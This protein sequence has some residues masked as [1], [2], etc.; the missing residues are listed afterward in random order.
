MQ[1]IGTLNSII[2]FL[3]KYELKL[4]Y[5]HIKFGAYKWKWCIETFSNI[6][7]ECENIFI[8]VTYGKS[9]F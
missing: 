9:Q 2:K 3:I 8:W 6:I 4:S 1:I 7:S 5:T